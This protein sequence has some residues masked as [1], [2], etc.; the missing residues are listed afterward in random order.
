MIK[1]IYRLMWLGLII[2]PLG[3]CSQTPSDVLKELKKQNIKYPK[4]VLAQSILETG[5]YK[6][7]KCSRSVNNLFG[8]WDS[9]NKK[10]FEYDSWEESVTG[11]YRGI[12]YRFDETK[13]S[14][15]YDFLIKIGYATDKNYINKLKSIV[16]KL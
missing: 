8:L 9:R 6:C 12:Q 15:Y 7:T 1:F 2:L 13:Y 14:D 4:I 16:E 11:Y 10:Y 3:M 5:W